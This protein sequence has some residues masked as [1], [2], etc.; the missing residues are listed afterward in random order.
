MSAGFWVPDPLTY[1]APAPL[2]F[3]AQP[4]PGT[5]IQCPHNELGISTV[6]VR[7]DAEGHFHRGRPADEQLHW[8]SYTDRTWMSW[9]QLCRLRGADHGRELTVAPGQA[10]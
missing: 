6:I 2:T 1:Q 5:I 9:E 10:W 7:D 8:W 3:T 4:G